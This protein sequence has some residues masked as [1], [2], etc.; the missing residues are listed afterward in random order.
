MQ[1]PRAI[2]IYNKT[3]SEGLQNQM[4]TVKDSFMASHSVNTAIDSMWNDLRTE[5][6]NTLDEFVPKKITR[7]KTECY[8]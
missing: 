2:K 8:G 6:E 5:L 4:S 7:T 1:V 3:N